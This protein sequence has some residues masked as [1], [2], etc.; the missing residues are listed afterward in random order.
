MTGPHTT[1][2]G[3]G[4][5][6]GGTQRGAAVVGICEVRCQVVPTVRREEQPGEWPGGRTKP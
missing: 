5:G 4:H 6:D 3:Q 2:R 1:W